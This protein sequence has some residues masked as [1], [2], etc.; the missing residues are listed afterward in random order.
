MKRVIVI[1]HAPEGAMEMMEKATPE[2]K[3]KGMEPWIA[4][5]EKLGSSLVDL[6]NPLGNGKLVTDKGTTDSGSDITGFS[7]LQAESMDEASKLLDGH[8]HL[9]WMEGCSIELLEAFPLEM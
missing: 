3:K 5:K 4:W 6:G 7:I 8:P 9:G 1:Y 2:E